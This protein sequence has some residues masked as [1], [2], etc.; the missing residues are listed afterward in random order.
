METGLISITTEK[1]FI[2]Q[3]TVTKRIH[4]L[5]AY[6]GAKLFESASLGT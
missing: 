3:F 6:F 5:E 4:S 1:L 2:P